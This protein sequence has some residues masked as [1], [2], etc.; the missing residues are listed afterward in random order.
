[1]IT[2]NHDGRGLF[3]Y[4]ATKISSTIRGS[5][6][7]Q[8]VELRLRPSSEPRIAS[9]PLVIVR[10]SSNKFVGSI[11]VPG[12]GWGSAHPAE[13]DASVC[14]QPLALEKTAPLATSYAAAGG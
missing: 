8:K 5:R 9:A 12:E 6:Q 4:S 7:T 2:G 11:C 3:F 1:M 14:R 13:P 10:N